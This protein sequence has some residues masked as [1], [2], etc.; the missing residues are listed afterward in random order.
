MMETTELI[1]LIET[2]GFPVFMAIVLIGGI[3]FMMKWMMNTLMSK[4]NSLW[5]MVVK[6]IDRI[7]ALDNSIIRL[8]TMIRILKDIDPDW[9]RIGKLDNEDKRTD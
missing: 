2:L 9:E 8:E 3:Y 5:E 7:R 1:S 6:L 4:L